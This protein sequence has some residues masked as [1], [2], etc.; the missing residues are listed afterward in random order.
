MRSIIK[1]PGSKFRIAKQIVSY[2]PEHKTYMEPFFGS[3]AVFFNKER[4]RIE[5]INDLDGDVVNFFQWVKNDPE[6]LA[7]EIYYTPYARNVYE[8]ACQ[9]SGSDSLQQAVSFC[10]RLNMGY[11]FRTGG[12]ASGWK[13]D[14][15]GRE[16]SYAAEDWRTLPDRLLEVAE[17]LRGVQIECMD[18]VS[19]IRKYHFSDVLLY[20]DPP[21]VLSTRSGGKQYR[22]EMSDDQH[23]ELLGVLL[24]HPG[25]VV[26]SGYDSELYRTMLD[27]WH[28]IMLENYSQVLSRKTEVLW[29][30]YDWEENRQLSLF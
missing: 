19:L 5:T 23:R 10:I 7:H 8:S 22:K 3:G 27:G 20:C 11:G 21:Y 28:R 29:L 2:F 16:R 1:Y 30:N 9:H 6:Q 15:H 12:P 4:S 24:E 18:A 25:P 13:S 26:L 17:R 14:I